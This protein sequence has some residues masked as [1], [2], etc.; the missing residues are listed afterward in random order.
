LEG[1]ATVF[2]KVS[3]TWSLMGEKKGPID[4]AAEPPSLTSPPEAVTVV[5]RKRGL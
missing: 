1:G 4:A 2:E 3:Y 5:D